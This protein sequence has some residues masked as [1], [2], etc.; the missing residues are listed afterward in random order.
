MDKKRN[1]DIYKE[2]NAEKILDNLEND[3]H[4]WENHLHR[5]NRCKNPRDEKLHA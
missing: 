4:N 3:I 2:F 1:D 5:M